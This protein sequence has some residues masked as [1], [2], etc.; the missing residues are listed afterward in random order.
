MGGAVSDELWSSL[1][2]DRI[3]EWERGFAERAAQAKALAERSAQLSATGRAG[4]GAVEVTVDSNGQLTGVRLE[5]EIRR[6]PAATTARQIMAAVRA[7]QADLVR[8]YGQV[9]AETV[10]ADSET[11]KAVLAGLNARLAAGDGE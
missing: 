8:Q 11:G 1:A 4:D 2:V 9:T 3:D 7:A 5:E 6:Q 10:G